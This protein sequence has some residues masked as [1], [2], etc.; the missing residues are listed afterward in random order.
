MSASVSSW[1][2]LADKPCKDSFCLH[3]DK[4][5]APLSAPFISLYCQVYMS[6]S[7]GPELHSLVSADYL[8]ATSFKHLPPPL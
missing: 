2:V 5:S 4:D 3:G 1:L 7:L 6:T 8:S